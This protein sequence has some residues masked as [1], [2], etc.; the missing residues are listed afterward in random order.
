MEFDSFEV[1]GDL[2]KIENKHIIMLCCYISIVGCLVILNI[3]NYFFIFIPRLTLNIFSIILILAILSLIIIDNIRFKYKIN[4]LNDEQFLKKII[5]KKHND[6]FEAIILNNKSKKF[7]EINKIFFK[8]GID[9]PILDINNNKLF[10]PFD[11]EIQDI[12][13]SL[14]TNLNDSLKNF[15][16]KKLK[17]YAI[18]YLIVFVIIIF[19]VR[20]LAIIWF[21]IIPILGL[22][23]IFYLFSIDSFNKEYQIDNIE[24]LISNDIIYTEDNYFFIK[25]KENIIDIIKLDDYKKENFEENSSNKLYINIENKNIHQ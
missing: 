7:K 19:A 12:S 3:L 14:D 23:Y 11:K 1:I 18:A 22:F 4:L 17:S 25:N 13:L 8:V 16:S 15:K 21:Y 20:N 24:T 9:K 5:I 10:I 6:S 2:R